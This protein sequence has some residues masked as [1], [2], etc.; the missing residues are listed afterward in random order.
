M[1]YRERIIINPGIRSGTPCIRGT[2]MT[3]VDVLEY[4]GGG[5]SV[6]EVLEEFTDLTDE[7]IEACLAFAADC[8]RRV[9]VVAQDEAENDEVSQEHQELLDS[10]RARASGSGAVLLN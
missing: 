3:V 6:A 9:H 5:M 8:K 1:N 10:I 4:L 2:R 7:D